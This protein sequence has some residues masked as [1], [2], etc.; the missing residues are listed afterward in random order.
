VKKDLKY[1][2]KNEACGKT[3]EDMKMASIFDVQNTF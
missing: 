2:A 1:I 3:L